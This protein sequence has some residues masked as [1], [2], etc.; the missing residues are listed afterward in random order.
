[1][2]HNTNSRRESF[3]NSVILH[4]QSKF[5]QIAGFCGLVILGNE[6]ISRKFSNMYA[7]VQYFQISKSSSVLSHFFQS[8]GL[9][10]CILFIT[11]LISKCTYLYISNDV[12]NIY[13]M[14]FILSL[15]ISVKFSKS[16]MALLLII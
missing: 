12:V 16:L 7:Y 1:M 13:K 15:L 14:T 3:S 6:K 10:W 9:C 4:F 2:Y 5:I 8:G 11:T